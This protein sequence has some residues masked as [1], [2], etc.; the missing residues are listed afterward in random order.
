MSHSVHVPSIDMSD[1]EYL[2]PDTG[3]LMD[4]Y[5]NRGLDFIVEVGQRTTRP[6]S[7]SMW[8]SGSCGTSGGTW[9]FCVLWILQ[10]LKWRQCSVGTC[11]FD[12]TATVGQITFK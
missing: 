2:V 9:K 8:L 3:T 7:V 12:V 5:G 11:M 10:C 4:M 1:D 6:T